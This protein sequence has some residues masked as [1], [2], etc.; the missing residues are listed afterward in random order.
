MRVAQSELN[1]V[2]DFLR[3]LPLHGQQAL[4][5]AIVLPRP[6]VG[7]I[8]HLSELGRDSHIP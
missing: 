2:R 4:Q 5:F 3:N 8:F 7:L 6:D 1:F